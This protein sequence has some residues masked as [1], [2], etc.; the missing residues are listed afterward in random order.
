[1]QSSRTLPL[2]I[3]VEP[4]RYF[5]WKSIADFCLAL[6]LLLPGLPLMAASIVLV[7]LTSRGPALFRQC[8]V[9]INGRI[10]CLYKIRS[11]RIDAETRTGPAWAQAADPRVTRVGHYLRKY[12]LDELPQLFNVLKGE[13]SLVGPRPERPEFVE[14]LSRQLPAYQN[15]LAVIPGITGL[16]QVNLPPDSDMNSV[17]RKV[18]LDLEYIQT[19]GLSMDLRLIFCTALRFLRLPLL[20]LCRLQRDPKLPDATDGHPNF[21]DR[22]VTLGQIQRQTTGKTTNGD[23]KSSGHYCLCNGHSRKPR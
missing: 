6:L 17:R 3:T 21:V 22:V 8:R 10:F 9:G 14:I 20:A 2:S 4:T 7:R 23:C 16:A 19:A 5:R 11:M 18:I 1:L 12:H 13:M 15:R